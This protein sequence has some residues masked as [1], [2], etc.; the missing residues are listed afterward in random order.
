MHAL[1]EDIQSVTPAPM[2]NHRLM[3]GDTSEMIR[4]SDE[5]KLAKALLFDWN[6]KLT[7]FHNEFGQ[8][9]SE[10]G[11]SEIIRYLERGMSILDR[12]D[13]LIDL[14]RRIA[15]LVE[16]GNR[17]YAE[18]EHIVELVEIVQGGVEPWAPNRLYLIRTCVTFGGSVYSATQS[19]TSG[20]SEPEGPG[21][22]GTVYWILLGP[23][24]AFTAHSLAV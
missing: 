15:R 7:A 23:V 5:E 21:V 2:L 24:A 10:S 3:A 11:V 14:G 1:L 13:G 4:A 12:Y 16:I 6:S 17:Q 22:D 20:M 9:I 19:G 18:R 8:W